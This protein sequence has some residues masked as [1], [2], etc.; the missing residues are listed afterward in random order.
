MRKL[1][2]KSN[3][4]YTILLHRQVKSSFFMFKHHLPVATPTAAP[5]PP[6]QQLMIQV[7]EGRNNVL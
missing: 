3:S 5:I 6:L 4:I 1:H 2:R 7:T